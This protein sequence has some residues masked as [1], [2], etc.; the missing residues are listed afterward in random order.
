M[1][2]CWAAIVWEGSLKADGS[3][4]GRYVKTRRCLHLVESILEKILHQ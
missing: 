2:L 4:K 3:N 1:R